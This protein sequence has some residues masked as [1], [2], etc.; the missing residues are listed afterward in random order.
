MKHLFIVLL[1][2]AVVVFASCS[3]KSSDTETPADTLALSYSVLKT[4]PHDTEAYTEGLLIHQGKVLESTGLNGKSWVAEVDPGSGV[5]TKKIVL[6]NQYFGEGIAVLHNKLYQL[7]YKTQIGFIYDATTYKQIGEFKYEPEGWGMTHDNK[8]LIMSVGTEKLYYLDTTNLSVARTLTVTNEGQ[9]LKNINELEF[10][11]GYIFANVYE[12][13]WIVKID[14]ATGKV[15][16]RVDLSPLTEEVRRMSPNIDYLNGIAYDP[17]SKAFLVTGKNW[18]K[19]FL[20]RIQ[21]PA[22]ATGV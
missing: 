19:T 8:N 10:V 5:H 18:P 4:L 9:K 14:P 22:A 3:K 1:A 6:D 7:T 2:A 13:S 12:T 20:I 16:G 17:N 11:D 15:V 21:K